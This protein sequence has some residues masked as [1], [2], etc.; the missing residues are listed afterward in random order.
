MPR[1]A[2]RNDQL[3]AAVRAVGG[4]AYLSGSGGSRYLDSELFER[5]GLPVYCSTPLDAP[6]PQ[7]GKGG[8]VY[9]LSIIDALFNI[10]YCQTR[11]LLRRSA[12]SERFFNKPWT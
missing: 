9:G 11:D 5:S 7:H 6:Y 8:W 2:G 10:G 4:T 1:R 3:I 12:K